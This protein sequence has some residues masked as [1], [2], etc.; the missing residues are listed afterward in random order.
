MIGLMLKLTAAGVSGAI[1]AGAAKDDGSI[2]VSLGSG[3]ASAVFL[4]WAIV[5]IIDIVGNWFS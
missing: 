5:S 4:I 1:A 3:A 2:L